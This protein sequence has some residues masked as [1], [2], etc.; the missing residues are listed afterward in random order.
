[1]MKVRLSKFMRK[2]RWTIFVCF[3]HLMS[4]ERIRCFV[5]ES[6]QLKQMQRGERLLLLVQ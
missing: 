2:Q 6:L 3:V 1:M 5:A 4:K